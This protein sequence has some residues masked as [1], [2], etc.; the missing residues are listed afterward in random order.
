[1]SDYVGFSS[2]VSLQSGNYIVIHAEVP[3]VDDVTFTVTVTNPVT[4][5][6][7]GIAVLRIA[8]KSTQTI[9]V[10]ASKDGYDD[11]TKVFSLTGLTCEEETND[12]PA[13]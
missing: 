6:D 4:L 7:D 2:D 8:D 10:V 9:T 3:D 13:G 1:M 5:D 12:Q 11:V